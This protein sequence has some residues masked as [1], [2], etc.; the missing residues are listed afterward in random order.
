MH[1]GADAQHAAHGH[2]QA[3]LSFLDIRYLV[4]EM[5]RA[6]FHV[7]VQGVGVV[8][9]VHQDLIVGRIALVEEHRLDLAGEYVDAPDD[10]HIVAAAHGLGHA[11]EVAPAGALLPAQDADVP[12]AVAQ[13]RECLLVQG[14]ED[15]LALGAFRQHFPGLRVDDLRIEMVLIDVHA[16]LLLA[17]EG[18]ARPAGFREAVDVI[19]LD[20]QALLDAAAHLLRPGFRPEDADAQLVV[21]RLVALLRQGLPDVGGIGGGTADD[22][23]VQVHHELDLPVRAAGGHREGQAAHLVA[24]PVQPGA[25]GEETV[26]VADLDHVVFGAAG[27]HDSPGGAVVPQVDVM[28]GV[29]GHDTLARGAGGGVDADAVGEVGCQQAVGVGFPQVRFGEEGQLFDVLHAPDV[30]RLHALGIHQLSVVSHV[31]VNV[32]DLFDDLLVLD[33]KDLFPGCRLDFLLIIVF[34]GDSPY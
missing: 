1:L 3:P 24:S 31:V 14:G 21:L 4:G 9:P 25:A 20:A 11:H 7:D 19:G 27:S 32:L 30:L 5:L 18:H 34:H 29:E 26:A 10:H 22:G 28:L 12:G 16:V 8:H 15:Q 13:E 2:L 17:L 33:R 6:Q 23:G